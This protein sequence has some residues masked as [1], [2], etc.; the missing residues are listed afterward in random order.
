MNFLQTYLIKYINKN[1]KKDQIISSF[2]WKIIT[3]TYKEE[4]KQDISPYLVSTK[5][6]NNIIYIKT[7]TSIAN[8]SIKEIEG[9]LKKKLQTKL[10]FLWIPW[11]DFIIRYK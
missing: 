10:S 4:K 9:K 3:Q 5:L 2:L 8:T 11:N 6:K 1:S 7:T